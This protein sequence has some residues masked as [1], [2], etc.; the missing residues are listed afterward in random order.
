MLLLGLIIVLVIVLIVLCAALIAAHTKGST[1]VQGGGKAPKLNTT[2]RK[3]RFS[4]RNDIRFFD[5]H[6]EPKRVSENAPGA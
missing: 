5:K 6:D 1:T 3:V 4:E 2:K